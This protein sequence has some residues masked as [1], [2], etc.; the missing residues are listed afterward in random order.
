MSRKRSSTDE[1]HIPASI[2]ARA[3]ALG[4]EGGAPPPRS[5]AGA[6]VGQREIAHARPRS[7]GSVEPTPLV[8][9]RSVEPTRLVS[10]RSVEPTPL[11]PGGSVEP[12]RLVTGG[13]VK[14]TPR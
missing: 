12:A 5:L 7:G 8:P 4:G 3:R 9:G 11:V 2:S 1:T 6:R 10:G 14:P 13:S